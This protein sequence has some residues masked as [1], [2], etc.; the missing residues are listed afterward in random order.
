MS[1]FLSLMLSSN[2]IIVSVL[3]TPSMSSNLYMISFAWVVFFALILQKIL[4]LPVVTWAT[5]TYGISLILSST[6]CVVV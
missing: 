2:E 4:N 1:L 6:N 5:V 3:V